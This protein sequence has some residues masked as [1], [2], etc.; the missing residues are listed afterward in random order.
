MRLESIEYIEHEGN[1]QEWSMQGLS[2]GSKNL[3]VGKNASGK[4]RVL[5]IIHALARNLGGL[6]T[7]ATSGTYKACF[8]HENKSYKYSVECKA[9]EVINESLIIN[10]DVVLERGL[11]GN[12]K[13]RA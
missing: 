13:I 12:G 7:A 6:Q 1:P 11:G 3:I 9:G 4:S 8:T 5:N 10:N 2:L